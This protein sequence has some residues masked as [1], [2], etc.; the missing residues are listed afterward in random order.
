MKEFPKLSRNILEAVILLLRKA[1]INCYPNK[2]M[3][4]KRMNSHKKQ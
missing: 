3:E 1:K 4:V 2:M